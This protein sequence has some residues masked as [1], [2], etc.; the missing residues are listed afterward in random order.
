[1]IQFPLLELFVY[2]HHFTT[3]NN[4][5]FENKLLLAKKMMSLLPDVLPNSIMQYHL[6]GTAEEFIGC[7]NETNLDEARLG[8][9]L[10]LD[11]YI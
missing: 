10:G 7:A 3:L 8:N 11:F 5:C 4:K 1:M 6:A 9:S 2:D